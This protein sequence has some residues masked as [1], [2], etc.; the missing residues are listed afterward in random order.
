MERHAGKAYL[1]RRVRCNAGAAAGS[2][3]AR[4]NSQAPPA[5]SAI[6]TASRPS[7]AHITGP[8]EPGRLRVARAVVRK[9]PRRRYPSGRLPPGK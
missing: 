7:A 9:D 2:A 3:Y 1:P 8:P 6:P 4:T 5:A